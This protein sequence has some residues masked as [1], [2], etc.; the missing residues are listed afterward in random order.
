MLVDPLGGSSEGIASEEEPTADFENH[1]MSHKCFQ[2]AP[3]V[4]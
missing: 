3:L 2:L 1:C 4:P